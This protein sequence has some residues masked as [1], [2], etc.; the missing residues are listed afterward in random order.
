MY[1]VSNNRGWHCQFQFLKYPIQTFITKCKIKHAAITQ[2]SIPSSNVI[3]DL[4][5]SH[6]AEMQIIQF[7]ST[8][9]ALILGDQINYMLCDVVGI[10]SDFFF[11]WRE[12]SNS[13]SL[14][15]HLGDSFVSLVSS[16]SSIVGT[17]SVESIVK[18]PLVHKSCIIHMDMSLILI[19][20][21]SLSEYLNP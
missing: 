11:F 21:S 14:V 10:G 6:E 7:G 15:L 2:F 18:L 3:S 13:I 12:V 4:Q 19:H 5:M 17:T 20:K 1:I 16:W 9:V 8:S